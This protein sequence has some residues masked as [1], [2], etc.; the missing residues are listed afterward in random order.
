MYLFNVW[1]FPLHIYSVKTVL[2]EHYN[3]ITFNILSDFLEILQNVFI[4][5][6]TETFAEIRVQFQQKWDSADNTADS[7]SSQ[8]CDLFI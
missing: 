4:A 1:S 7:D 5:V 2:S 8:V 3:C 6:I